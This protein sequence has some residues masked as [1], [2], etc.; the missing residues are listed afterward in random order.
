MTLRIAESKA[1][2]GITFCHAHRQ[3]GMIDAYLHAH[4]P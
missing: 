1:K 4:F 2:N 3:A